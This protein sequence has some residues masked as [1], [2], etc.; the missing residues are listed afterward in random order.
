MCLASGGTYSTN[1]GGVTLYFS[2]KAME[3]VQEEQ[4][5]VWMCSNE[6]CSCWMRENF[7]LESTPDCP[8]CH[9]TMVKNFKML[10][11]LQN[12]HVKTY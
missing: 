2:K 8:I 7:S 12:H 10:P 5:S 4:T 3:P 1:I 6:G 11:M 9:A